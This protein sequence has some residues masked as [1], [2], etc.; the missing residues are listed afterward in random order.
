MTLPE[1]LILPV[2]QST[3]IETFKGLLR[4]SN[5]KACALGSCYENNKPVVS[6]GS[7]KAPLMFVGEA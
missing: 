5:C 1:G 6:R 4:I 3:S 2:L 7:L